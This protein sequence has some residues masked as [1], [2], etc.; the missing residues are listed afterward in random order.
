MRKHE[1]MNEIINTLP[2]LDVNDFINNYVDVSDFEEVR[3]HLKSGYIP[4][5]FTTLG[6]MEISI[7]DG[8][9]E[10]DGTSMCG[11]NEFFFF[12]QNVMKE[13]SNRVENC[14]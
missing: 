10:Y 2:A 6:T 3:E 4:F 14:K 11:G 8:R 9:L 5:F 12:G 13:L 7:V 1:L